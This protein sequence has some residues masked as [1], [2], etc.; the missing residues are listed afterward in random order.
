VCSD[1]FIESSPVPVKAALAKMGR[2]QPEVRLPLA[3]LSEANR[4]RLE[5]TLRAA[6]LI[7]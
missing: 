7:R 5:E 4:L 1:L 2:C 3:P 6:K